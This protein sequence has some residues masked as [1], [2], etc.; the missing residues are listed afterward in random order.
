MALPLAIVINFFLIYALGHSIPLSISR[1]K[2]R[3]SV[4]LESEKRH[5]W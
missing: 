4:L 1:K 5:T 3:K 2:K